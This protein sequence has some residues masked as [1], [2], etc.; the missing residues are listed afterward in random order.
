MIEEEIEVCK[1]T[2]VT[3]EN[4]RRRLT[5][6]SVVTFVDFNFSHKIRPVKDTSTKNIV[7]QK[8]LHCFSNNS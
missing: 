7:K 6:G 1:R 4:R 2:I 3:K 8:E 5:V